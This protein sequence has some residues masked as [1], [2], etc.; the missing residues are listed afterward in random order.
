MQDILS[1]LFQFIQ[2]GILS[3]PE[4]Y[5]FWKETNAPRNINFEADLDKKTGFVIFSSPQLPGLFTV[6]PKDSDQE[7]VTRL[8]ND[9]VYTYF[10]VPRYVAKRMNDLFHPIGDVSQKKVEFGHLAVA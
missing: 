7:K 10:N 3:S 8:V 4:K 9:A 6:F 1:D 2:Y 5:N